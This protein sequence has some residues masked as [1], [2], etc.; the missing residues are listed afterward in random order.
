MDIININ[1][2]KVCKVCIPSKYSDDNMYGSKIVQDSIREKRI[3]SEE[4][5]SIFI[6]ILNKNSKN[7]EL[8][9]IDVGSNTG[10]FSIIAL[11]Y[12][13]NVFALEAN[14]IYKKYLE[15]SVEINNFDRSKLTY[16]ENFVSDTKEDILFDGWT[17]NND[18][19]T[20][21]EKTFVK[22]V[23]LDDICNKDVLILKIDVEGAEPSVFKSAENLIKNKKIQ[24]IIFELTY[25]M[26]NKLI[27]PQLNILPYLKNNDFDLYEIVKNKLVHIKNIKEHVNYLIHEYKTN[28]VV[29]NPNLVN[30]YAGTNILAVYKGNPVPNVNLYN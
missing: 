11:S 3:W 24:Y 25:I 26:K 30:L 8:N 28:H 22:T 20:Y 21:K 19:M 18:M 1:I 13:C 10:Y 14:P 9:I 17:G 2:N 4:E 12:N 7:E 27:Y 6:D 29:K 5:T 15:K 16:Y 23:S